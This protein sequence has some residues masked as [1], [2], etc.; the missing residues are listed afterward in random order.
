MKRHGLL[1]KQIKRAFQCP[2]ATLYQLYR[3]ILFALE[4]NGHF[5]LLYDERNPCY[6]VAQGNTRRGLFNVVYESLPP[7]VRRKCHALPVQRILPILK[8]HSELEWTGELE[9]KYF[10]RQGKT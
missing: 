2:F 1:T 7:G 10:Q 4:K 9:R 6:L 3:L 8:Q 5:L